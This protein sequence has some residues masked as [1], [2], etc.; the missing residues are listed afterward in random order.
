M[1]WSD[2]VNALI[3]FQFLYALRYALESLKFQKL[4][5]VVIIC[6]NAPTHKLSI[7]KA[8][9][10][11]MEIRTEF[12]PP[13]S[14]TLAPV[15]LMFNLIKT[16]MRSIWADNSCD[17][18]KESGSLFLLEA[19]DT[20]NKQQLHILWRVVVNVCKNHTINYKS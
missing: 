3:Y 10:E 9:I 16:K 1:I 17:F 15:E 7:T 2:T 13:Y 12:L 11:W 19:L 14:P 20:V 18:S 6:D 5:D 8:N 4:S